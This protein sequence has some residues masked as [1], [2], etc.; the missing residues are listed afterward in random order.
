MA[1]TTDKY[2]LEIETAA[3][4]RG[5]ERTRGKFG[6]LGAAAGRLKGFLG[7][8]AAGLAA[9]AA[10]KGIG[11][12]ITEMD[13][14]AKAARNAGAAASPEAFEGFQVARNLLGEM[15][16]SAA[17]S[18]RAFKNMTTRLQE[19]AD[20]GKG[21][22][23]TAFEKLGSSILDANGNL[24]STPELFERVTQALQDGTLSMTDAR[25]ILGDVV[26]PKILGGFEDLANKG[27]TAAAALEDV[28]N[29]SDIVTLDAANNAE[30]FGD[31]MG[32]LQ[33]VSGRLVTELVTALLPTLNKLA[34]GALKVLPDVIDFVKTAFTNLE[35]VFS[36]IGKILGD[37]VVPVL[38]SL[39]EILG[40][41]GAFIAPFIEG[42]INVMIAAF[43]TLGNI[44]EKIIGFFSS[45]ID[46][47]G[48][49][50]TKATELASGVK[51]AFSGMGTSITN[52]AKNAT[53]AVTGFFSDM[54]NAVVGN[55]YVPDMA[56]GVTNSFS[57]MKDNMI[58]LVG[59]AIEG[60]K[61]T[62]SNLGN[63]VANK[64]QEI[65]GISV[66][67]LRSQMSSISSYISDSISSLTSRVS[68]ALGGIRSRVSS[69]AS[70]VGN[71]FGGFNISNPFED[72][73]AGFFANG[74]RIPSGQ[75]GIAGE[76][77]PE[78][79]TGPANVT[80][81]TSGMGGNVTYN[82]NAVDAS[83][84]RSLLAQD[85]EFVHRVVQRGS[86]VSSIGR[87]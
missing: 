8:V 34:E 29:N 64:F 47:L 76:A 54:Y 27:V 9:I 51:D 16:L 71:F 68:S 10:V 46:F 69:A 17:E 4:E 18:D 72:M 58:N 84:F 1:T 15:G 37:V 45:V 12:K 79:I 39:F 61:T 82:I 7:P 62:M 6:G 2:I 55:S 11:D 23:A 63:A 33:E 67:S 65:T 20:T 78:M 56:D 35:P 21:P 30:A 26:G 31:T 73:F 43:E 48:N 75:F 32:R 24:V 80:P 83:S 5:I 49:I 42:G 74:G 85:P 3:A 28:K 14:L 40:K 87:R 13:D 36:L 41:V 86:S 57:Q 59:S 53:G 66:S 50:K 19:A 22:A 81:L 44:V 25:K 52:T 60:V 38:A 77:G 70:S